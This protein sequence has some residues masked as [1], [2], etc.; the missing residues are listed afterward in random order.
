MQSQQ[1][2]GETS[3]PPGATLSQQ[4]PVAGP[5][6]LNGPKLQPGVPQLDQQALLDD[7]VINTSSLLSNAAG[8]STVSQQSLAQS[9]LSLSQLTLLEGW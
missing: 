1:Q 9:S 3:R 2:G 5:S 6:G 8:Q 7:K 4:Q